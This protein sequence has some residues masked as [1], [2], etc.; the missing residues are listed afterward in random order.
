MLTTDQ[1]IKLSA[2]AGIIKHNYNLLINVL[3]DVTVE[4]LGNEEHYYLLP[5]FWFDRTKYCI[6]KIDKGKVYSF[7]P[8]GV[9]G[10]YET[11]VSNLNINEIVNLG[12]YLSE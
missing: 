5:H 10:D 8:T 11:T 9:K 2:F 4:F 3:G 6:N 12:D 1:T 7:D